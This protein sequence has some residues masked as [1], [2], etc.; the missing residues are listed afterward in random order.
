LIL[1]EQANLASKF[2]ELEIGQ[3]F[4]SHNKRSKEFV[5]VNKQ[6]ERNFLIMEELNK[7]Q[8]QLEKQLEEKIV[9]TA[10]ESNR[11][12]LSATAALP[13]GSGRQAI[14]LGK[15]TNNKAKDKT[16]IQMLTMPSNPMMSIPPK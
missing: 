12:E 6:I 3:I 9:A 11:E 4:N 14:C 13:P 7:R 2:G 5:Q 10:S 8:D 16:T 1:G 15:L